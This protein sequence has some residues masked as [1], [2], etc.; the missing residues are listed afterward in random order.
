MNHYNVA[1]AAA[2]VLAVLYPI[3]WVFSLALGFGEGSLFAAFKADLQRL[4]GWD[5]LF[6]L[7]GALEV[8]VYLSLR[9]LL[10]QR[11]HAGLGSLFA[12][13][14]AIVVAAFTATVLFDLML[15]MGQGMSESARATLLTTAAVVSIALA[16]LLSLIGALLG[17]A[18][19]FGKGEI[20]LLLKLFSV[21]LL[22]ASLANL[23]LVFAFFSLVIYPLALVLL[24]VFFLKDEHEVEVV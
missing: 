7:I 18:L 4:D 17:C 23:S 21:L 16:M 3:Y 13:L 11:L 5:A 8:Y 15:V 10:K 1:G 19:L 9:H 24:A 22:L 14:L 6:V 2:L 12:L 20:P